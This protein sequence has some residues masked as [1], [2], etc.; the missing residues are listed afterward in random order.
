MQIQDKNI[1]NTL[2]KLGGSLITDKNVEASYRKKTMERISSEIREAYQGHLYGR[3]ILGHGSGSFGHFEAKRHDTIN[4][5][6][7]SDD[8]LGFCKVGAVASKLNQLVI[9]DLIDKHIPVYSIRPSSLSLADSGEIV[10]MNLNN[11]KLALRKGL[12]PLVH[13]DVS[14]DKKLG[15]TIVS[16]ETIFKHL[17]RYLFISR[18]ILVGTVDG[19]FDLDKNLFPKITTVNFPRIRQALGGSDG[20]D[21]T[22]GMLTKVEDMLHLAQSHKNLT[23]QIINGNQIGLLRDVLL[24]TAIS[25][26]TTISA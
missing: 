1:P 9:E 2:V 26:G 3:L 24:N 18:I 8:W 17:A 6:N 20:T 10:E 11:M 16:T 22:G 5:V 19:V 4:G 7:T 21:V 12:I 15:G 25:A 13:G 14:F 23:I